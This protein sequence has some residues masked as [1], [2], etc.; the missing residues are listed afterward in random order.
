LCKHTISDHHIHT[1]THAS[2]TYPEDGETEAVR[3]GFEPDVPE[4]HNP[5]QVHNL[6]YPFKSNDED[7]KNNADFHPPVNEEAQRWETRNYS[8]DDDDD[9]DRADRPSPSYGSFRAERDAWNS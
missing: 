2:Q 6:D 9:D 1:N 3:E 8:D 4:A 5:E 7:S